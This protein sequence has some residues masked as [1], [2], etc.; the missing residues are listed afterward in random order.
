MSENEDQGTQKP[1]DTPEYLKFIGLLVVFLVV[2]LGVA[3]LSPRMITE[4]TPAVLGI[5]GAP[6]AQPEQASEDEPGLGGAPES[7][8]APEQAAPA[9]GQEEMQN[10]S[11]QHV[12]Q[13]GQT[14]FQIAELYGVSVEEIAAANNLV[15][16]A[17]L[18]AGAV[19]IIPQ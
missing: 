14:L 12:V 5:G 10:E 17:Q 9:G 8:A 15:S 18:Q 19:L 3:L 1:E 16:P 11:Q 4:V 7:S 6:A 2:I 13:A